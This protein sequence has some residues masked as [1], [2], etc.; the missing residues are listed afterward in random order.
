[1]PN[2]QIGAFVPTTNIWDPTEIYQTDVTSDAFKELLVRMYQNLN[3]MSIN[4]NLKDTGYYDTSEFVT[5]QKF[6]PK[7][8]LTS[9]SAVTPD[10]RQTYRKVINFGAL[11]NTGTTNIDHGI[12]VDA[13]TIFTR[14]YGVATDPAGLS[15]L[16]LPYASSTAA[17]NIEL[18]VNN[19][20]V[21]IITGSDR[22]A[23]TITYVIVEFMKF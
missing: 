9:L 11:P 21:T 1:M 18:S 7:P 22:S 13:N 23:Y 20:N 2:E 16:P 19:T 17:N 15:Y 3:I 14:I 5:G 6:F 12:T 8:G 10:F 4:L